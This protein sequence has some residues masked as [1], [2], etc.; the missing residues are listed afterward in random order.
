M[1][2]E[3][4]QKFLAWDL[5]TAKVLSPDASLMAN[6]PLGIS[7]AATLT[8]EGVLRTWNGLLFQMTSQQCRKLVEYLEEM[9]GQGYTIA[10]WNGA[11][12]DFLILAEESGMWETCKRLAWN[13]VDG[14]FHFFC[15][16]G[17]AVGLQATARGMG[18]EGKSGHGENAPALWAAGER[19]KV[20]AYVSQDVRVTLGVI[21][22]IQRR[23]RMDWIAKSGRLMIYDL[24]KKEL[25]TVREAMALPLPDQSWMRNPWK[26][27]KFVGWLE[28]GG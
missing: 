27:E 23:G 3:T 1:A 17:V 25:L 22:E 28:E 4:E 9:S 24:P 13:H 19:E 12:F 21:Q 6:R 14:M 7:C 11:G 8:S 16:E 10:T 15:Q 2:S 26:R 5:E 20:L 18:L